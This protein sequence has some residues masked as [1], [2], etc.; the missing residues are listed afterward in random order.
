MPGRTANRE[1]NTRQRG[2]RVMEWGC[3]LNH[4]PKFSSAVLGKK[5]KAFKI[6]FPEIL[7][8]FFFFFSYVSYLSVCHRPAE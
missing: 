3:P 1:W 8:F 5:K 4:V 7:V 6:C 2:A